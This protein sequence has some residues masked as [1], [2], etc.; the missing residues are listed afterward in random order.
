[1]DKSFE[2]KLKNPIVENK[3]CSNDLEKY[4][5]SNDK[6]LIHKW[7]HYFEIYDKYFSKF[8]N[9][10]P[11]ILEIGVSKGGS[12]Q[13]WKSYFGEGAKI[14]GIDIEP[15]CKNYEEDGIEIF[16]GSQEDRNFL[17]NVKNKIGNI[18]ILIDDGG[19]EMLQQIIT[20]EELYN[21]VKVDG[22]IYLCE[23]THSSY[24]N[25]WVGAGLKNPN[26]YIEMTKNL[27]DKLYSWHTYDIENDELTNSTY[28]IHYYDSVV[29][30]EK[31]IMEMPW[32]GMTS[33]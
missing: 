3:I 25:S 15:S 16:I 23:D 5:M 22:G 18:D 11:T 17:Q 1:M 13:M 20:F 32:H 8:R 4:F 9:K 31:R 14:Y 12:L 30:I 29:V 7:W 21:S 24:F 27:I 10:K 19:H 28:S 6:R 2:A 33:N 26:S